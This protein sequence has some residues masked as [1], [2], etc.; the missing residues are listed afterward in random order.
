MSDLDQEL[1]DFADEATARHRPLKVDEGVG[2]QSLPVLYDLLDQH[3]LSLDKAGMLLLPNFHAFENETVVVLSDYA[4][5]AGGDYLVYSFLLCSWNLSGQFSDWLAKARG[6]FPIGSRE[7]NFKN[8]SRT[9]QREILPEMLQK[10]DLGLVGYVLTVA[11]EKQIASLFDN[12]DGNPKKRL[13]QLLKDHDVTDLKPNVAEKFLRVNHILAYLLKQLA[14]P[15]AQ[16]VW[17]ITDNDDI[18]AKPTLIEATMQFQNRLI[19]LHQSPIDRLAFS[20]Q[21]GFEKGPI[22]G[23]LSI[24]DLAAGAV[25]EALN[26]LGQDS[27]DVPPWKDGA[28]WLTDWLNHQGAA[29]KKSTC[30]ISKAGT[31]EVKVSTLTFSP[32]PKPDWPGGTRMFDIVRH[33]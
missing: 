28:G 17:W 7:I 2:E 25:C 20:T 22:E 24:P 33:R 23:L 16:K 29:L 15:P 14:R 6:R 12:W 9:G 19:G 4:G 1:Q 11:V 27:F 8:L 5:D 21:R 10:A 3:F 30:L 18:C 26:L 32:K 13:A 31:G